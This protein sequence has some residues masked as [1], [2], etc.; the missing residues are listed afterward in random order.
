MAVK[1]NRTETE[2]EVVEIERSYTLRRLKDKDLFPILDILAK[3]LPED[4]TAL[5]AGAAKKDKKLDDIGAA[6]TLKLITAV[7]RNINKVHDEVY[8]LLADV[9]G[10]PAKEIEEMEFGTTPMMI[11]DIVK[12]EKNAGF[13]SVLSK[14]L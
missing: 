6:V 7:C 10:I 13:F 11:W 2:A 9:S 1:V 3:V 8:E 4:L 5:I 12:N 14:L